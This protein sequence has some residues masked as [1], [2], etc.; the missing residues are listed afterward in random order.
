MMNDDNTFEPQEELGPQEVLF[1]N[2]DGAGPVSGKE[3]MDLKSLLACINGI[4]PT[5]YQGEDQKAYIEVLLL[6]VVDEPSYIQTDVLNALKGKFNVSK[7]FLNSILKDA[8][9]RN[10]EE[11][12]KEFLASKNAQRAQLDEETVLAYDNRY[13]RRIKERGELKDV[14]ISN[15]VLSV[16]GCIDYLDYDNSG[17]PFSNGMCH[18][19]CEVTTKDGKVFNVPLTNVETSTKIKFSEAL[20]KYTH[21]KAV[22]ADCGANFSH[23]ISMARLTS[24]FD[25]EIIS[26]AF[27]WQG[28]RYRTPSLV[29]DEGG[30]NENINY[31]V[32]L[33]SMKKGVDKLDFSKLDVNQLPTVLKSFYDNMLN[34]HEHKATYYMTAVSFL[35]PVVNKINGIG[36]GS[37]L[38]YYGAPSSGKTFLVR[39]F[40]NLFMKDPSD[41]DEISWVGSTQK[42]MIK[43]ISLFKDAVAFVDDYKRSDKFKN[44]IA[45]EFLHMAYNQQCPSA[46]T[47]D[48]GRTRTPYYVRGIV[49]CTGEDYPKDTGALSRTIL[50]YV[51]KEQKYKNYEAAKK[52]EKVKLKYNGI[53]PHYIHWFLNKDNSKVSKLIYDKK[54]TL[55]E[56]FINESQ[57]DR[58]SQSFAWLWYG[59]DLYLRFNLDLKVIS[60]KEYDEKMAEFHL[61]VKDS[62]EEMVGSSMDVSVLKRFMEILGELINTDAVV[63]LNLKEYEESIIRNRVVSTKLCKYL[64]SLVR[65][66]FPVGEG[67][68]S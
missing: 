38:W 55:Q 60:Q 17:V 33:D 42:G 48:G 34:L 10:K 22:F 39:N 43:D 20:S 65:I 7:P 5:L 1:E 2:P 8:V 30:I 36:S 14:P 59:F 25:T 3:K 13:W 44:K 52:I 51:P 24:T 46:L 67:F 35:A 32:E 21:G 58:I 4:N 68:P 57:I 54:M 64:Q 12:Y 31:K 6:N 23:I 19:D 47:Q 29:I 16:K 61:L 49:V 37:C 63:I 15:F 66:S 9:K 45:V 28:G 53:I 62:M 40:W 18:F 11:K 50:V 41:G 56:P 27:G 26:R